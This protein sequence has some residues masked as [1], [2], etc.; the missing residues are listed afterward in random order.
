MNPI[1][2]TDR[3]IEPGRFTK[4]VFNPLVRQLTRWGLSVKG[5]RELSVVG[6]SSGEVRRVVV[7]LLDVDGDRYLVAPRGNTQWVRNVRAAGRAELRVGRHV[8]VVAPVELADAE[9]PAIIREYLRR[10]KSEVGMF[11]EGIDENATDDQVLAIAPGFPVFA[12]SPA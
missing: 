10:W 6:R 8:D 11:F 2:T 1:A 12:L 4:K 7:N 5:S 9:K 3:Y